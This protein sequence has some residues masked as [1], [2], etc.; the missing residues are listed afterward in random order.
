MNRWGAVVE[1]RCEQRHRQRKAAR[2]G[3]EHDGALGAGDRRA[4]LEWQM[5]VLV[6]A[7]IAARMSQGLLLRS[8]LVSL[9]K[10][11]VLILDVC[12]SAG[13]PSGHLNSL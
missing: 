9:E 4:A 5:L 1:I 7:R 8:G 12:G 13:K 10:D 2:L 3:V 6:T 11:V